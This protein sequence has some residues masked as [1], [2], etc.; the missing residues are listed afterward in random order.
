MIW[1]VTKPYLNWVSLEGIPKISKMHQHSRFMYPLYHLPAKFR[2]WPF[3][4]NFTAVHFV[5]ILFL[6]SIQSEELSQTTHINVYGYKENCKYKQWVFTSW[7]RPFLAIW[8]NSNNKKDG[9]QSCMW[10]P[11]LGQTA[12]FLRMFASGSLL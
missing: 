12:C 7:G 8:G 6:I 1:I 3:L 4:D 2:L 10:V 5:V 9:H 11:K